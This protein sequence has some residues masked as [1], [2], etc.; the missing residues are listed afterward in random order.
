MSRLG[1]L[2]R[3]VTA[4]LTSIVL[5]GCSQTIAGTPAPDPAPQPK[6]GKGADPTAW[7]D[8]VCGAL[9]SYYNPLRAQP[10]YSNANPAEIKAR[11]AEYLSNVSSGVTRGQEMVQNAGAS[12]VRGGDQ[13]AES[14]DQLLARTNGTIADTSRIVDE[15]NANDPEDLR[16]KFA[17]AEEKLRSIG[18]AQGLENLGATPRLDKA[19]ATAKQCQDLNRI[20]GP[21]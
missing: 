15:A 2:G 6:S 4:A 19:V 16:A 3:G 13:F 10:D 17:A 1:R 21:S 9:I 18:G 12:P 8:Q 11:L 14:I 20:S 7:A 5:A